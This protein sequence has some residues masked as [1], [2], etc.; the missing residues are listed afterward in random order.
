MKNMNLMAPINSLG[1]GIA[2]LNILKAIRQDTAVSLSI[3]GSPEI[4]TQEDANAVQES[5]SR[6]ASFDPSAPCLKVWHEF[7]MAERIGN[8]PLFGFPFFEITKFDE[9]RIRHLGSA[10]GVIVASK[11]AA[12]VVKENIKS[13]TVYVCPLGVD[14]S[15]F[16]EVNNAPSDV[17]DFLN[18]GK[19]E[20]RKGHDILLRAFQ[21]AFP[22]EK[23]VRLS[24]LPS[25]PFLSAKEV[26]EWEVY[27]RSD[28]RVNIINRVGTHAEVASVMKSSTCGVFPSRAEGW[29]L[30]LLEMM[31]CGKPVIATDYSAHTEFCND[32][33]SLLIDIDSLEPA[34]DGKWFNGELGEWASLEGDPFDSLVEHLRTV[35]KRWQDGSV[36]N[37][38]GIQT[39]IDFSWNETA[40]K[41]KEAIYEG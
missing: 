19:W 39:A 2:G 14:R 9:R 5:V 24:M 10:D 7:D 17:C 6:K 40:R 4:T 25:N 29:N 15:V 16:N 26:N 11:W 33:N 41:I 22:I 28:S 21:A 12:S 13:A 32:D 18:C 30:E 34:S 36:E 20:I 8:G 27:Y 23:D 35:Y 3:I 1:Y 37:A 38:A 31:S